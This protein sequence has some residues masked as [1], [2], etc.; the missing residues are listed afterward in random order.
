MEGESVDHHEPLLLSTRGY[1]KKTP[2]ERLFLSCAKWSVK[3][4]IWFVFIAWVALI[5]LYPAQFFNSAF[6]SWSR[7]SSSATVYGITG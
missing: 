3:F 5:F 7:S 2:N 4:A 1:V 6:D